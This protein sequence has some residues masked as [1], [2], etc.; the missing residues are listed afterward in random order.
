MLPRSGSRHAHCTDSGLGAAVSLP[1]GTA[2]HLRKSFAAAL[3]RPLAIARLHCSCAVCRTRRSSP[4]S[5]NTTHLKTTSRCCLTLLAA[6]RRARRWPPPPQSLARRLQPCRTLLAVPS[7]VCIHRPRGR[8]LLSLWCHA[9]A[10]PR[11]EQV[12][13]VGLTGEEL[14]RFVFEGLRFMFKG[15][16]GLACESISCVSPLEAR[17]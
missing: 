13:Q 8:C 7:T 15:K 10:V 12:E 14:A 1:R 4:R 2:L 9:R 6:S 16:R 17:A 11:H 3:R 5:C